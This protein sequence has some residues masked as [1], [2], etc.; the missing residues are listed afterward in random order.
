MGLKRD[1]VKRKNGTYV[2]GSAA[3][4]IASIHIQVGR[5]TQD[6]DKDAICEAASLFRASARHRWD[7]LDSYRWLS[8]GFDIFRPRQ[9][10]SVIE[11][12]EKSGLLGADGM[13]GLT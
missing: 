2:V 7:R 4:A 13:R 12:E 1:Q 11:T 6:E 5:D 9:R 8:H 10:G 3:E